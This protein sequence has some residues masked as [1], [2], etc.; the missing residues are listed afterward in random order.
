MLI[1]IERLIRAH[2][3]AARVRQGGHNIPRMDVL[4][5]FERSWT[6]FYTIYRPLAYE[7]WVFDNTGLLIL[8]EHGP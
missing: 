4:R 1:E 8:L 7:W 3:I 6:D 2:E 5:R